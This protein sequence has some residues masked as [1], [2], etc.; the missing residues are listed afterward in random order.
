MPFQV[1]GIHE[2]FVAFGPLVMDGYGLCYNIR[3]RDFLVGIS[4][5]NSH[6]DTD[7]RKFRDALAESLGEMH[8][9]CVQFNQSAKL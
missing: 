7:S 2:A 1:S 9:L 5:M 3:D 4:C 6:P 8:D